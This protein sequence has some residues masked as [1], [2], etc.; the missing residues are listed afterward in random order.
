MSDYGSKQDPA[1]LVDRDFADAW[2]PDPG[3]KLVGEIVELGSRAGYNDELYPIVTVRRDDGVELAAHC[4]HTVLRN[5]LAKIRPQ[6][7]QRIAIR[8]EG[9]RQGADGKSRYH[10]YRVATDSVPVFSWGAFGDAADVTEVGSDIPVD[11]ASGGGQGM[12][13]DDMPFA[14]SVI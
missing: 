11:P 2:R 4:F 12:P 3:G 14:A 1:E 5:E 10:A 13:D 8:Y 9:E 7:G 6:V